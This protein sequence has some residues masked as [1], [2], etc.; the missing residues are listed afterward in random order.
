ML[1]L[2]R[3]IETNKTLASII[4]AVESPSG[5]VRGQRYLNELMITPMQRL[6][7]YEL[8][9]K[10]LMKCSE[11]H[12]DFPALVAAYNSIKATTTLINDR[13]RE[14]DERFRRTH[15]E[16]QVFWCCQRFVVLL[17]CLPYS[18]NISGFYGGVARASVLGA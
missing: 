18:Q 16:Q 12:D 11:N 15:L 2:K 1:V 9:F 6:P 3:L 13:K 8:L 17:F 7:R 5:M 14:S 4:E 10:E